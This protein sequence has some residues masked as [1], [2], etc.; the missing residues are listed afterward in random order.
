MLEP[1]NYENL[2]MDVDEVLD[3]L[4]SAEKSSKDAE[5]AKENE[6]YADVGDAVKRFMESKSFRSDARGLSK[7]Y[8]NKVV[9]MEYLVVY[10]PSDDVIYY[11]L[12]DRIA[13]LAMGLYFAN[14]GTFLKHSDKS[15]K[16]TSGG[17]QKF[18]MCPDLVKSI[19]PKTTRDVS[20]T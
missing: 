2:L 18:N 5:S 13:R 3:I 7:N 11:N 12:L 14:V 10:C 20:L 9:C 19:A 8:L 4:S 1:G 16:V 15:P 17:S 6:T